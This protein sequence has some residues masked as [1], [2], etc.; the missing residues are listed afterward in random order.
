MEK[1]KLKA[2]YKNYIAAYGGHLVGKFV[3]IPWIMMLLLGAATPWAIGFWHV[4]GLLLLFRG[5][6]HTAGWSFNAGRRNSEKLFDLAD[7]V[8]KESRKV[9]AK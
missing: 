7:E 1:N 6:V 8:N 5:L 3:V 9:A 4:L 2:L